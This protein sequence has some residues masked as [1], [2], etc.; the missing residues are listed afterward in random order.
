MG[1]G[2]GFGGFQFVDYAGIVGAYAGGAVEI[3]LGVGDNAVAGIGAVGGS[4]KAV[5]NLF[6][7]RAALGEDQFK[8]DAVA[9]GSAKAGSAVEDSGFAERD[10]GVGLAAIGAPGEAIEDG[11]IPGIA[12]DGRRRE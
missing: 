2:K 1:P 11:I 12:F 6:A 9:G 10:V 7:P 4:G 8:N 5:E 3:A